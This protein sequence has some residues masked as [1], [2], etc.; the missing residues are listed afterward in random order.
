VKKNRPVNLNLAAFSWPITAISSGLHRI[1]GI[2]LFLAIPYCLWLLQSSLTATGF[3]QVKALLSGG[4]AKFIIWVI[5][6]MLAYH[7]VAGIRHIMMD[8]GIGESLEGGRRGSYIVLI[9]GV[10]MAVILGV[11]LW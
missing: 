4:I 2:L 1:T 5:L 6:S 10:I 7:V 11:S 9:L 8:A 3:T